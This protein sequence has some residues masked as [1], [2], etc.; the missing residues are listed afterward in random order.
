MGFA[1]PPDFESYDYAQEW[2]ARNLN[3][4][5]EKAIIRSWIQNKSNCLELGSGLGRIT[6]LLQYHCESVVSLDFSER[7]LRR[8]ASAMTMA[9]IAFLRGE[10]QRLPFKDDLFDLTMLVRVAHYFA[11]RA[12]LLEE[13]YRVSKN[14]AKII[15]S[16]PNPIFSNWRRSNQTTLVFTGKFGHRIYSTPISS[17]SHAGF[18][19]LERRGTG[20][21]ENRIA[22]KFDHLHCLYHVDVVTSKIWFSKKNLFLRFEIRK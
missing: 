17:F 11:S 2:I 21:F 3:D 8:A 14:G 13:I 7:N 20:I 15:I 22:E 1:R 16:I 18:T 6:K 12:K 5:A 19:L 4:L 9:N 10:I